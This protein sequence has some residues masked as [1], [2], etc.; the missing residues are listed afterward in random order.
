LISVG[1][2]V[3]VI[4]LG[5]T[6]VGSITAGSTF[7]SGACISPHSSNVFCVSDIIGATGSIGVSVGHKVTC[8][9]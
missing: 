8:S 1:V 9:V 3:G 6:T 5:S 7:T 4:T 2:T